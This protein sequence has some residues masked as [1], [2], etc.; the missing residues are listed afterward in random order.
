MGSDQNALPPPAAA[1][2]AL[3]NSRAHTIHA[4]KL[5]TAQT[6]ADVLS[7]LGHADL[8]VSDDQLSQ[9]RALR[10]DL[11]AVLTAAHEGADT[12]P[13]W[14]QFT[15]RTSAVTYQQQFEAPAQ[16]RL[17][18]AAG[19]TLVGRVA[20]LTADLIDSGQWG[21]LRVC[22]NDVCRSVFYDT[23]RSRTQRWHSYEICGNKHNVAS[24]RARTRPTDGKP[25]A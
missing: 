3:L 19:D 6:A 24:Y 12:A 14:A 7:R 13:F 22:A 1:M 15:A 18:Q 17:R 23:T 16:V 10:S 11:M 20:R 21:R 5:E 4:E 25:D 2:V 9:L 8:G